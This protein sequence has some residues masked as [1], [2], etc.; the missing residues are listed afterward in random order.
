MVSYLVEVLHVVFGSHKYD[1]LLLRLHNITQKIQ[2]QCRL[3]IQ[4]QV[5]KGQLMRRNKRV[6]IGRRK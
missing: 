1:R 2:Q 5:K 4:T 6:F 3:V